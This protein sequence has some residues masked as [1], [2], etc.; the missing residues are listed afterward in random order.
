MQVI[1]RR[2]LQVLIGFPVAVVSF[3]NFG[4]SVTLVVIFGR[5]G[6]GFVKQLRRVVVDTP[7]SANIKNKNYINI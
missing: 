3:E 4:T 2:L 6:G 7:L 5:V 1:G